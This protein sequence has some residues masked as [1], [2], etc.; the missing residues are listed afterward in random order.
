[1]PIEK[2]FMSARALLPES[3][4]AFTGGATEARSSIKAGTS[5]WETYVPKE[6]A[7]IAKTRRWFSQVRDGQETGVGDFYDLLKK[8][9]T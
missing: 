7:Q 5:E 8:I 6:V 4:E 1:M 9:T 2:E 3:N